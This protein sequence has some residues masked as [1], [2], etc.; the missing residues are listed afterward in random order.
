MAKVLIYGE[1]SDCLL[2]ASGHQ[3]LGEPK[4]SKALV[5]QVLD[6]P[7]LQFVHPAAYLLFPHFP[8]PHLPKSRR[9]E[10]VTGLI[11]SLTTFLCFLT[12]LE[13]QPAAQ[14]HQA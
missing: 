6:S 10:L 5:V 1:M 8:P 3:A 14:M 13:G 2:E 9:T 11:M 4:R 12:D 7:V